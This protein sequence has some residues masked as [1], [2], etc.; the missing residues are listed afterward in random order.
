MRAYYSV[1]A[2]SIADDTDL[3][4]AVV[5]A[6]DDADTILLALTD[7]APALVAIGGTR[8][9]ATIGDLEWPIAELVTNTVVTRTVDGESVTL[10]IPTTDVQETDTV[11]EQAIP[12]VIIA[13]D[14]IEDYR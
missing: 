10:T 14:D 3:G 4:G 2:G 5:V 12:R 13:G 1:P 9:G 8:L 6:T 11:V 7:P